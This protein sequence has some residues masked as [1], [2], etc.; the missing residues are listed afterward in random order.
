V[1]TSP[2]GALAATFGNGRITLREADGRVRWEIA[3]PGV[4]DVAWTPRGELVALAGGVVKLDLETGA[5]GAR[6]CGWLFGLT[7]AATFEVAGPV[8]CDAS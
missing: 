6:H 3:A 8:A 4:T 2:D 1:R 7:E 5:F